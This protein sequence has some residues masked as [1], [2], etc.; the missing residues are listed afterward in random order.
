[1]EIFNDRGDTLDPDHYTL[2]TF[3][4]SI[5]V[6]PSAVLFLAIRQGI[7]LCVEASFTVWCPNLWWCSPACNVWV[8]RDLPVVG[9]AAQHSFCNTVY[10]FVR[11]QALRHCQAIT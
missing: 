2:Q 1:M 11:K 8:S 9:Q 10:R 5:A 6:S 4:T 3:K 7:A